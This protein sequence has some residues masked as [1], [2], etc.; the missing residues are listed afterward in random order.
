[1]LL[2]WSK[3][4]LET[5]KIVLKQFKTGKEVFFPIAKPL[6]T[7]LKSALSWKTD[8]FGYVCLKVAE[9]YNTA[10][11]QGK[12]IGSGLVNNDVLRVLK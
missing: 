5:E 6:L 1:M 8:D 9:R 4:N 2:R 12:N 3:V 10:D 11:A 7:V